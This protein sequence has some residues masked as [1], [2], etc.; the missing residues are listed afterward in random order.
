MVRQD[1]WVKFWLVKFLCVFLVTAAAMS[2]ISPAIFHV[3]AS[4]HSSVEHCASFTPLL[5]SL[6]VS[7]V[8]PLNYSQF[9]CFCFVRLEKIV[10][11]TTKL[12]NKTKKKKLKE[13]NNC[14]QNI[15]YCFFSVIP[16]MG[17]RPFRLHHNIFTNKLDLIFFHSCVNPPPPHHHLIHLPILTSTRPGVTPAVPGAMLCLLKHC[18]V[19]EFAAC[20]Q[21]G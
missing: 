6:S 4:P 7:S 3:A 11:W 8:S 10:R 20:R 18:T 12:A 1:E 14:K 16:K 5:V 2:L 17:F 15:L 21:Y 13:E 9:C 19:N